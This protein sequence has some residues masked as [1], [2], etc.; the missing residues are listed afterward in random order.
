MVRPL[1]CGPAQRWGGIHAPYARLDL[2]NSRRCRLR[3]DRTL[4]STT[5]RS[6]ATSPRCSTSTSTG[7]SPPPRR[8]T[9]RAR[10]ARSCSTRVGV[11]NGEN[12]VAQ[13]QKLALTNVTTTST[14][15]RALPRE[16]SRARCR[17]RGAARSTCRPRSRFT[18]PM[19]SDAPTTL[20]DQVRPDLQRRRAGRRHRRQ[21]L[22]PLSP[23]RVGLRARRRRR[24][25]R[26]PRRSSVSTDNSVAKY[27]EYHKVWE[28]GRLHDLRHLRQV[29]RQ[30]QGPR[31]TP[32]SP[33]STSSSPRCAPSSRRR[34]RS[35]PTC[36][37]IPASATRPTT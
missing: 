8:R 15:R 5:S 19:R 3:A 25:R 30:R 1:L 13:L 6:P 37:S 23:A 26:W 11:F 9:R 34:P 14:R 32:A 21:L 10:S 18:L 4:R 22:V 16:V 35:R 33:R 20:Q 2:I 24:R 17:S 28:D 31:R 7:S 29:R 12:G 36:R 27:P